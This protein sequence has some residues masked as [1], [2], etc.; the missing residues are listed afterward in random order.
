VLSGGIGGRGV[1]RDRRQGERG[2]GGGD[3]EDGAGGATSEVVQG[4]ALPRG[5]VSLGR[6]LCALAFGCRPE[7]STGVISED[8]PRAAEVHLVRGESGPVA[9]RLARPARAPADR[10]ASP[11]SPT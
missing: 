2:A 1:G 8:S 9:K 7:S 6:V 3:R 4:V 5:G 10:A 11:I